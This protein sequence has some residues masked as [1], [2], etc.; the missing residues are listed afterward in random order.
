MKSAPVVVTYQL[1][2][3]TE[4]VT[5]LFCTMHWVFS[6][7]VRNVEGY[8]ARKAPRLDEAAAA[9]GD[10]EPEEEEDEGGDEEEEKEESNE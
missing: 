3:L 5:A 8:I 9:V 2:K 7:Q 1:D 4:E 6:Q 10:K